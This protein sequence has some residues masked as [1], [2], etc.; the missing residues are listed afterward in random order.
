MLLL[1]KFTLLSFNVP[2]ISVFELTLNPFAF[3][4]DAVATPSAIRVKLRPVTPLAGILYRF[5]PSP[6]N[7]P[8]I[9]PV[10]V[11]APVIS[12]FVLTLKPSVLEIDAVDEP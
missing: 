7:E 8:D 10:A 2:V 1:P 5:V 3:E 9:C 12:V 4:M 11:N 6:L